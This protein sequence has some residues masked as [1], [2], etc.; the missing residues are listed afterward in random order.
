MILS[1]SS[2][3][4]SLPPF[5]LA[6]GAAGPALAGTS[7]RHRAGGWGAPRG[8][9]LSREAETLGG[10]KARPRAQAAPRL[11]APAV[12]VPAR[13]DVARGSCSCGPAAAA[14][15]VR[16]RA[17]AS[18]PCRADWLTAK[19]RRT[20]PQR[21]A[22]T[23]AGGAPRCPGP[24]PAPWG[25]ACSLLSRLPG[26]MLRGSRMCASILGMRANQ[27][28]ASRILVRSCPV[29]LLAGITWTE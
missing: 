25:S 27:L 16:P 15:A 4:L 2:W 3:V 19:D 20:E 26:P 17:A 9:L 18:R 7:D 14:A 29:T 23:A 10:A 11:A 13:P 8:L 28:G 24:G 1:T 21:A 22:R 6:H 12:L 5:F